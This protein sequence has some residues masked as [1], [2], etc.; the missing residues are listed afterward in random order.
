MTDKNL[1]SEA[2][3]LDLLSF[4]FLEELAKIRELLDEPSE[5][6]NDDA[7]DSDDEEYAESYGDLKDTLKQYHEKLK[8]YEKIIKEGISEAYGS[9]KPEAPKK[10]EPSI[11]TELVSPF[12]R[13]HKLGCGCPGCAAYRD[14]YGIRLGNNADDAL[15]ILAAKTATKKTHYEE[16]ASRPCGGKMFNHF[17]GEHAGLKS[18]LGNYTGRFAFVRAGY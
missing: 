16:S 12:D 4:F 10:E 18:A 3:E 17:H 2:R 14:F 8:A 5:K 13:G 1:I 11:E 6:E 7:E 15:N 9:A